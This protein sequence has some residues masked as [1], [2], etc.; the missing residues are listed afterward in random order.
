MRRLLPILLLAAACT[1]DAAPPQQTLPTDNG[2]IGLIDLGPGAGEVDT[3]GTPRG[4]DG[5]TVECDSATWSYC[6]DDGDCGPDEFCVQWFDHSAKT[7]EGVCTSTCGGGCPCDWSCQVSSRTDALSICVPPS[8]YQCISCDGDSD[9]LGGTCRD[10]G[11][12]GA[13]CLDSCESFGCVEGSECQDGV[14]EPTTFSCACDAEVGAEI[15]CTASNEYGTCAGMQTCMGPDGFAPCDAPTASEDICNGLDDD[16]D[17]AIDEGL[18]QCLDV[19]ARVGPA[20]AIVVGDA[21][22]Q[23]G[24][25]VRLRLAIRPQPIGATAGAGVRM[26]LGFYAIPP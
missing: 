2:I 17:G 8:R 26:R 21:H 12:A 14:C 9:C 22:I 25:P 5:S 24:Q 10:Y 23:D 19:N 1:D 13:F 6:G 4:G 7:F 16:C 3:A 15:A 11:G 18:D 20:T